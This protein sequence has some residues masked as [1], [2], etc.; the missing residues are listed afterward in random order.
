MSSEHRMFLSIV[1]IVSVKYQYGTYFAK[2]FIAI[3]NPLCFIFSSTRSIMTFMP[4]HKNTRSLEN[5]Y[6]F[7]CDYLDNV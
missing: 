7:N 3:Q 4:T 5:V 2:Y 1:Y 6:N